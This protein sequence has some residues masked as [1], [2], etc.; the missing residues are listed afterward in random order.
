VCVCVCV[1]LFMCVCD[2][3]CVLLCMCVIVHVCCCACVWLCMC[4]VVH[5]CGCACVWLCMCVIVHVCDCACVWV[6]DCVRVWLCSCVLPSH[7]VSH[8]RFR[9]QICPLICARNNTGNPPPLLLCGWKRH[10]PE[11]GGGLCLTLPP[12]RPSERT[13]SFGHTKMWTMAVEA[14][15]YKR[16]YKLQ[17]EAIEGYLYVHI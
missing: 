5:V 3:A 12:M 17:H 14:L 6:C 1:W 4:V 15:P 7:H 2:C 10:T 16:V 11:I 13:T 9:N 8:E